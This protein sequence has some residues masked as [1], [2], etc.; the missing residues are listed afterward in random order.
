VAFSFKGLGGKN[1]QRIGRRGDS[2]G[3]FVA[4]V[5][6]RTVSARSSQP[7][8]HRSALQAKHLTRQGNIGQNPTT[9]GQN[10]RNRAEPKTDLPGKKMS[11]PY[12]TYMCLICGWI[13]EEEK[14]AP[15]EGLAPAR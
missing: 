3:D 15:E 13:Y 5:C 2:G 11:E 10:P 1:R 4:P 9:I 8:H 14:G 7:R 6:A 12:R